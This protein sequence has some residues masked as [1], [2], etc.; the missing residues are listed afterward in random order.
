MFC[1]N[2]GAQVDDGN[3][4]CPACGARLD[5]PALV[6]AQQVEPPA[7][8]ARQALPAT[9]AQ[10]TQAV[11]TRPYASR[12]H[13]RQTTTAS[14]AQARTARRD[15]SG[16]SARRASA[17]VPSSAR[18]SR[19]VA[20]YVALGAIALIATIGLAVVRPFQGFSPAPEPVEQPVE[21]P[22]EQPAEQPTQQAAE[23][24]ALPAGAPEAR[25]SLP[26]YSWAELDQIARLIEDCT[27][28]EE[29]LSIACAY[30]LVDDAGVPTGATKPVQMTDGQTLSFRV[31]DVWCDAAQTSSGK[32]GIAFLATNVAYRHRMAPQTTTDGGW[33]ASELRLWM[34]TDLLAAFPE[35]VSS[36]MLPVTKWSNN[37]G[38][39]T[40]PTCVTGTT[41]L[42]WAPSIVELCGPIMW[43][44]DSDPDNSAYYSSVF[45][46]EGAQYAAF[47][48]AHI[49]SDDDNAALAMGE[50][51]WL[52]STAASSGRGRRVG[53]GGN[54]ASFGDSNESVGVVCGFC[55]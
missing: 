14:S 15:R 53:A 50:E 48:Q 3:A 55:L 1:T 35:E 21:Q 20:P 19:S 36:V 33:E 8:S 23:Q 40:S 38:K 2:C 26:D 49:V 11:R 12:S 45:N 42:L 47:S 27:S 43:T 4:F 28:R 24:P 16:E 7:G 41:D 13:A 10:Q 51:W 17:Y 32:A 6:N 34:N 44:F 52:R 30:H 5:H 29:A 9:G 46:A 54:P 18:S 37:I 31:V 25:A 39:T 22:A